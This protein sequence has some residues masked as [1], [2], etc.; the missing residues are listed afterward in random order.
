[1]ITVLLGRRL[2]LAIYYVDFSWFSFLL[3]FSLRTRLDSQV[4]WWIFFNFIACQLLFMEA[5][6]RPVEWVQAAWRK[7][8]GRK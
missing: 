8:S 3:A 5:W 2:Q 4:Q 7:L 6:F 1:M